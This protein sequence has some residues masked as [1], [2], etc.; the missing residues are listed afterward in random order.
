MCTQTSFYLI[1][2]EDELLY[3]K[4]IKILK[5]LVEQIQRFK[6]VN[7]G[8]VDFITKL[9]EQLE[10]NKTLK[11]YGIYITDSN[12][13]NFITQSLPLWHSQFVI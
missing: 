7:V 11:D 5:E 12:I 9:F 3:N 6:F 2:V 13:T 1:E 10:N 8:N 4:N